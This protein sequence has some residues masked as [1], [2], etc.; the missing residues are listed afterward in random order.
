MEPQL[1]SLQAARQDGERQMIVS[2]VAL[3]NPSSVFARQD[4]SLKRG[5]ADCTNDFRQVQ[6]P[7]LGGTWSSLGPSPFPS[8]LPQPPMRRVDPRGEHRLTFR[9]RP[10]G[11]RHSQARAL[12]RLED[13]LH[14][15]GGLVSLG[16]HTQREMQLRMPSPPP[17]PQQQRPH[18]VR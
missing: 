12:E 8:P 9:P 10:M 18:S 11:G 4:R 15:A 5:L 13:A 1:S 6:T 16:L 7:T 17:P 3:K 14:P 2:Q